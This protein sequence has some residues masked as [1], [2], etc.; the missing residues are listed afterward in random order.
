MSCAVT[1]E[2]PKRLGAHQ[3]LRRAFPLGH[4]CHIQSVTLDLPVQMLAAILPHAK[5]MG[6]LDRIQGELLQ[7]PA[8]LASAG[9]LHLLA[10]VWW[11]LGRSLAAGQQELGRVS[12]EPLEHRVGR[13]RPSALFVQR[14]ERGD[15]HPA[16]MKDG[17]ISDDGGACG[18]AQARRLQDGQAVHQFR[19]HRAVDRPGLLRAPPLAVIG[20]GRLAGQGRQR[21]DDGADLCVVH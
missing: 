6:L 20:R 8:I 14:D 7:L 4:M 17:R 21:L 19:D 18:L 11:W 2:G 16:G 9:E 15:D 3:R 13:R 10:P 5:P 1:L 12:P